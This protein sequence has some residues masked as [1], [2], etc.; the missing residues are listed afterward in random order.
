MGY[1]MRFG[2]LLLACIVLATSGMPLF[3]SRDG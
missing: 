3:S 1:V 2:G